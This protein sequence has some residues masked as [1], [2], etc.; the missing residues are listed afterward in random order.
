MNPLF[1]LTDRVVLL[2]GATGHLGQGMARGLCAAG[3]TVILNGRSPEKLTAQAATLAGA[4][5]PVETAAFDVTD[6]A[7]R[8]RALAEIARTHGRLDVLVNNAYAPP[9]TAGPDAFRAAYE[10]GVVGAWALIQDS[11]EL[12]ERAAARNPGGASV[13]NIASMYGVVSPDFAIYSGTTKPNPPYYGPAKA[14]LLQMTRYLACELGPRR[15]RV[16]AISPGPFPAEATQR[17]DPEFIRRLGT[18]NPLGRIGQPAELAGP[19]VF[20]ASDAAS[21]VTGANLCVDGGWT[22]W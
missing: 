12:L 16:N 22:A 1:D 11:L 19:V 18:K 21:Y 13:I 5:G 2:T 8:R 20:L 10:I 4:G 9:G 3:A 7:A 14:G 15:I 17:S 6:E